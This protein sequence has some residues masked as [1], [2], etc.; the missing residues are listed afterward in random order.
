MMDLL[1]KRT[2]EMALPAHLKSVVT[3]DLVDLVNN[4]ATDP[5]VAEQVRNNFL[6]YT[7]VMKE[8]KFK[9]SDYIHAVAFVSYRLMGMTNKE[10][11]FK[12]FPDRYQ[13]LVAKGTSDKNMSAYVG[14]YANN[15]LVN[16]IMEQSIVPSW[17]LNRDIYQ[18]AINVQLQI[19]TD[20]DVSP[21]VRSDA[22]NSILVNLAKPKDSNIQINMDVT[23][24]SGMNEL[25]EALTK[26]AE[27]QQELLKRGM[28][29]KELAAQTIID[30]DSK[31]VN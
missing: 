2:I 5:I 4:I 21:K 23:E 28:S 18:K 10:A 29:P 25:K 1:D 15:K 27:Q 6:S 11:Y 8:G 30:V 16:L 26:M 17:V 12:T 3:A 31:D 13:S 19:M 22:A 20:E 7:G 24:S 9:L 14:S